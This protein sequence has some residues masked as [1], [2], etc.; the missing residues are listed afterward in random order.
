MKGCHGM[1]T[2]RK[3]LN[4]TRNSIRKVGRDR[5]HPQARGRRGAVADG[6]SE[7]LGRDIHDVKDPHFC[8]T[9]SWAGGWLCPEGLAMC[10]G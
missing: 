4:K 6:V 8:W 2:G 7:L 9:C 3:I 5:E 10:S 1:A